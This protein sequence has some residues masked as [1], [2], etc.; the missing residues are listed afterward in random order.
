MNKYNREEIN[1]RR[2]W[3]EDMINKKAKKGL[4]SKYKNGNFKVDKNNNVIGYH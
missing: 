3:I 1:K 4:F 2:P